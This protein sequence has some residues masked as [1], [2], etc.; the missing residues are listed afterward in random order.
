ME[1]DELKN[2]H[3]KEQHL[4]EFILRFGK[5]KDIMPEVQKSLDMTR[6]E[7]GALENRPTVAGEMPS[8]TDLSFYTTQDLKFTRSSLP[9]MPNYDPAVISTASTVT[10]SGAAYIY[11]YVARYADIKDDKAIKFSNE[12][13]GRYREIQARQE[14]PQQVRKLM[15]LFCGSNTLKRFDIAAQSY[16]NLKSGAVSHEDAANAIRN[17]LHGLKGDLWKKA[18]S[19]PKENMNWVS[20]SQRLAKGQVEGA[21]LVRQEE[22]QASLISGLSDILKDRNPS[23][24]TNLDNL[25]TQTLDFI[26]A[27]LNL[28]KPIP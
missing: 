5:A 4:N 19:T 9:L 2:L 6:W 21:V 28:V 27:V 11:N 25:W 24:A 16:L 14:R 15:L 3:E 26:Y 10:T 17:V 22:V 13:T 12:Q 1:S 8:A 20:M 18:Q 23:S 7:I